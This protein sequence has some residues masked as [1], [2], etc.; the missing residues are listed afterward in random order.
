MEAHKL[1]KTITEVL[2]RLTSEL[3]NQYIGFVFQWSNM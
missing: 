2:K 1:L 3:L